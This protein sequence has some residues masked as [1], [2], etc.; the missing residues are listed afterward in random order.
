MQ[1]NRTST[2]DLKSEW[3]QWVCDNVSWRLSPKSRCVRERTSWCIPECNNWCA[4]SFLGTAFV[5]SMHP[6]SVLSNTT[7]IPVWPDARSSFHIPHGFLLSLSL[8]FQ[9]CLWTPIHAA[10]NSILIIESLTCQMT[11]VRDKIFCSFTIYFTELL[12]IRTAERV[13]VVS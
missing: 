8:L 2:I 3:H 10:L 1:R 4:P 11:T 12:K 6:V 13:Q 7:F 5:Y 9:C